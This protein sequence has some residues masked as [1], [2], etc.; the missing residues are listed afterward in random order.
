MANQW[1]RLYSEFATDPKIQMLSESDQRRFIMILCLK[2]CNEDVTLHDE[3][4]AFQLRISNQEWMVTK[5]L[6]IEKGI[7]DNDN[8]PVSWAKRQ[9]VSDSSKERVA[10]HRAKKKKKCNVTVTPPDTDTDT[11]TDTD[12][13]KEL[14]VKR[15]NIN[16][17]IVD[18]FNELLPDLPR[19]EKLSDARKRRMAKLLKD[20][21]PDINFWR[22][23]FRRVN[24]S[25][26]LTGKVNGFKA[27]FDWII[28]P[29]NALKIREGN[30][31]N[32]DSTSQSNMPI[33]DYVPTSEL[34]SGGNII[35]STAETL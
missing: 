14:S 33:P 11:D 12:K 20:D 8:K 9:F 26:F 28:K 32:K 31:D 18:S 21:L 29:E 23:F 15:K 5:S 10:K 22:D 30:Y 24:S 35:E 16:S 25:D 7:L 6:F 1:F 34:M 3:E 13:R 17:L 27:S 19:V 4:V 2:C